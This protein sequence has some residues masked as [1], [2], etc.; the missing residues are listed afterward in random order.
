MQRQKIVLD[1]NCLIASLSRS[2]QYYPVW[3]GLQTGKYILCVSTDIL[4]EYAEIITRKMSVNVAANVIHLL[5]ESEFVELINTY[6]SL[7]L[8]EAD[9]D[10]DKF[11]DCA[12]AANA[13]Y[14]V[15]DDKHYDILKDISFPQLLVLKLKEFLG[16]L[17]SEDNNNV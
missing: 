9:H 16:L 5:L 10:D 2:G 8:I 4:E 13:T 12:F 3:K 7:H 6:F 17:Q 15:S 14:I 11:V 1:T